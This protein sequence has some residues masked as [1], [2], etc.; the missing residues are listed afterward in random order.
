MAQ[1]ITIKFN[2]SYRKIFHKGQKVQIPIGPLSITYLVGPNGCGKSTLLRAIRSNNDT[3]EKK[4]LE[5]FDRCRNSRIEDITK[6]IK[7]GLLTVEGAEMYSHIFGFDAEVDNNS[8]I[9]NCASAYGFIASGGRAAQQLSRGQNVLIEFYKFIKDFEKVADEHIKD[10]N[11]H[12]LVII[13]EIDEGLDIRMQLKW[14]KILTE[15]FCF[16]GASV[17]VVSHNP[18]CMLSWAPLVKAYD[19]TTRTSYTNPSEYIENLTGAKIT[20]DETNKIQ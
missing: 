12:P 3:L 6:D 1:Y 11:W 13:D 10:E 15:K 4:R 8:D 7:S 19:V 16:K 2:D 20:I 5:M 18:I 9:F 17:L 14:N